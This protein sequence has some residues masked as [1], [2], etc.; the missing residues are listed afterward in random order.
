[1]TVCGEAA[2]SAAFGER[3]SG[4]IRGNICQSAASGT[5]ANEHQKRELSILLFV[6][7][8]LLRLLPA[9]LIVHVFLLPAPGLGPVGRCLRGRC[10]RGRLRAFLGVL[11][12]GELLL[13]LPLADIALRPLVLDHRL[14]GLMHHEQAR[15][16][17]QRAERACRACDDLED[18]VV[19]RY[20]GLDEKIAQQ[21]STDEGHDD[22]RAKIRSERK[23]CHIETFVFLP[24][25]QRRDALHTPLVLPLLRL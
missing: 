12:C 16:Q 9:L 23:S 6:V 2:G 22:L 5:W 11:Q 20:E 4:G 17:Q 19:L 10:I 15:F 13:P 25:I 8:T 14:L 21:K 1:M 7:L 18:V 3:A 24:P